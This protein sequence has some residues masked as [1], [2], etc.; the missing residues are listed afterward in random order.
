MKISP[1]LN[2]FSGENIINGFTRPYIQANAWEAEWNDSNPALTFEWNEPK[3]INSVTF[4]F[5]TDFDHPMESVANGA[6]RRCNS[7]LHSE[8]QDS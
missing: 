8:L 5:D 2:C 4:F 3:Q 7:F 1:A 6:S